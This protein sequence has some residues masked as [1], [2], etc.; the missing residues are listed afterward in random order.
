M[1]Y[2]LVYCEHM[3]GGGIALRLLGMCDVSVNWCALSPTSVSSDAGYVSHIC[4]GGIDERFHVTR[5]YYTIVLPFPLSA[6]SHSYW[7]A[8]L[9]RR[10][11]ELI[12]I[13]LGG[14][15]LSLFGICSTELLPP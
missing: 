15:L 12:K 1:R 8:N 6:R 10:L 7:R 13:Y 9:A 2:V 5:G 3:L 4:Q 11:I 14:L